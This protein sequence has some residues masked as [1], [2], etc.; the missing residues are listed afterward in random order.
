MKI[1]LL[2]MAS[3]LSFSAHAFEVNST[4]GDLLKSLN[5]DPNLHLVSV[6][7]TYACG[8]NFTQTAGN[9]KVEAVQGCAIAFKDHFG[10]TNDLT[11]VAYKDSRNDLK[12]SW[13]VLRDQR[14]YGWEYATAFRST[15]SDI[16]NYVDAQVISGSQLSLKASIEVA[17]DGIFMPHKIY[18][19][20]Q[21]VCNKL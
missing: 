8:P 7:A 10:G 11:V 9:I 18:F 5:A 14:A 15:W 17:R 1:L 12:V 6:E 16:K 19:A 2:L 13:S 3:V 20:Y 21:T 4:C